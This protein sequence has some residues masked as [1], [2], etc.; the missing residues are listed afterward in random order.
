MQI[1]FGVLWEVEI[2]DNVH[3]LN[4]NTAGEKIRAN[5]IP[6]NAVS[7]IVEDLVAILLKHFRMRIKA[8]IAEFG[9]F[10]C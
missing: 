9:D 7:E 4:I 3:C 2:N 6:R 5:E 10:L 1:G 8:G